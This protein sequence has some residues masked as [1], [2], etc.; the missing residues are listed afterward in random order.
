MKKNT[1]LEIF[2]YAWQRT[3]FNGYFPFRNTR[4]PVTVSELVAALYI[5]SIFCCY[6]QILYTYEQKKRKV[7]LATQVENMPIA[8][9]PIC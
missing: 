9:D 3:E 1:N 4:F 7:F 6:I 5:D 8:T 2:A